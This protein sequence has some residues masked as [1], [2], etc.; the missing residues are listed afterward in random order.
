MALAALAMGCPEPAAARTVPASEWQVKRGTAIA[1]DGT[2]RLRLP[3]VLRL[4]PTTRSPRRIEVRL[5]SPRCHPL[6][7]LRLDGRERGRERL[8]ATGKRLTVRLRAAPGRHRL[9]LKLRRRGRCPDPS[10]RLLRTRLRDWVPIGS[11]ISDAE[12]SADPEYSRLVA[13]KVDSVT[14]GSDVQWAAVEPDRGRFRFG[15]ADEAV[16]WAEAGSL[17]VRGHPL[18]WRYGMPRWLTRGTWTRD[19][20][21][22]VMREHIEAVVG[23]YRGRISEWDV[24]NEPVTEAGKLRGNIWDR[25]IGPDYIELAFRFAHEADPS[26]HLFINDF[27]TDVINEKSDGIYAIAASLVAAGAPIDGVGF[28]GHLVTDDVYTSDDVQAN[29]HRFAELG[30]EVQ[31]TEVD[32]PSLT[33]DPGSAGER[34]RQADVYERIARAC[35]AE[36]A[37]TRF[38]MWGISDRVSWLGAARAPL[39]FDERLQPKPA[40]PAITGQLRPR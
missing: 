11:E 28:Q 24:V 18:I 34:A 14:L 10:V 40:W 21:I 15:P 8:G 35:R 7:S 1:R 19:E 29:L 17:E 13:D 25:I 30:L 12:L 37:C 32:V 31:F 22:E 20:L 39:P 4:T 38:T 33:A 5:R 23:R 6:A 9:S 27:R 3:S 2:L 16:Q 36:P 26:A